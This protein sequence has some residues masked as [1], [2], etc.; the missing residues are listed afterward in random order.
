MRSS[1]RSA[2]ARLYHNTVGHD[3]NRDSITMNMKETVNQNRVLF[4]EWNPQ[5]MHNV[6]QTGPAGSVVFIPPFRDPFNY[7]VDP[8]IPI[9]I[10]QVGTAM[11]GAWS[12]G[13]GRFRDA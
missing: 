7:D 1:A 11:H 12:R 9:G 5:I 4:I 8:L 10:E 2:A 6:H 3:N 13:H